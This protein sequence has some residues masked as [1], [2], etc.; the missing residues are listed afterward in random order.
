MEKDGEPSQAPSTLSEW[1]PIQRYPLSD[2]TQAFPARRQALSYTKLSIHQRPACSV[3]NPSDVS[4]G[5]LIL[6]CNYL[7]ATVMHTR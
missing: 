7:K 6:V 5:N 1:R 3:K 2:H 4:A